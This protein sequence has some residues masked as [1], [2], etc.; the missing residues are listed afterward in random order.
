M[1]IPVLD[2]PHHDTHI[3]ISARIYYPGPSPAPAVLISPGFGQTKNSLDDQA[4]RFAKSGFVVLAYTPRGFGAS[5]G[6]IALN[7]PDYEVADA[8]GLLDWLARQP[9]VATDRPGDPRVGVTGGSYGGALA[10]LLAGTDPRVDAIAPVIT[11]NNLA[12][13]LIPNAATRKA[14]TVDTRTPAPAAFSPGGVF[15]K[16][17]A[18]NLYAAGFAGPA[19]H[20]GKPA[21]GNFLPAVCRAYTTLAV[22]GHAND[23]IQSLLARRSPASVTGHITAPTLLVQGERDTL[24]GLGQADENARQI[25]AAGATVK[26]VWYPGGH[27]GG[28]P[29]QRVRDE[30]TAWFA[31]Y[32]AGHGP[33]PPDTF[34]YGLAGTGNHASHTVVAPSYPGLGGPPVGRTKLGLHGRGQ[35]AVNPPGGAPAATSSL[36]GVSGALGRAAA[37]LARDVPGEYA[38][39]S[40]ARLESQARIAGA[41]T[42]R[43]RISAPAG[44]PPGGGVFFAKLYDVDQRGNRTLPGAGVAPFRIQHFPA[45]AGAVT[46]TVTLPGIVHAV[47][48]GHHLELV[49]ATTDRAY[50]GG[51]QPG[52]YRIGLARGSALAVPVVPGTTRRTGFPTGALIGI[53]VVLVLVAVTAGG[54]ALRRGRGSEVDPDRGRAPLKFLDVTKVYGR[55]RL[56]RRPGMRV[57]DEFTFEVESGQIVGLLGPNG[58][59]KTTALRIAMG[60]V[61]PTSGAVLVFGRRVRPGAP[62][63][64]RIGSF[65]EGAGFLPH[66]SGLANLRLYW[67]ATGRPDADAQFEHALEIAELGEAAHRKVGTYSQGMRQRLAIA[68]AMLGLPA[69]L[70]LDEPTNGLDPPQIREM[71]DVLRRYAAGGR[72]VVIS[73]HLLA[74]VEQTCTHIVVMHRGR[75]LASGAVD[76]VVAGGAISFSVDA[77]QEA[78]RSLRTLP[79]VSV[80]SLDSA[81]VHAELGDTATATA[82][83]TLVEAGIGVE[84]VGPRRRLEDA[85]LDLLGEENTPETGAE[86]ARP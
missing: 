20:G 33:K 4:R 8:R 25:S 69:L 30:I 1:T 15:K 66:E 35:L 5:G 2:G 75:R 7:D 61:R 68:Q 54:F 82:V 26:V 57:V 12:Q 38:R 19:G 70:V 55:N 18:A 28:P 24:F 17:W 11:Y 36:P 83:R 80:V 45:G 49:V 52:V 14:S 67:A 3:E 37:K 65:V 22:T 74:E 41:V 34:S 56:R 64:S 77:P 44:A 16:A 63:L 86:R 31:H 10:L 71:R 47:P 27:D 59:G 85:F 62:V 76:Q 48:A 53:G 72:T 40:S 79:G 43:L 78:A 32:L 73:S 58:A 21:C 50:A 39:F 84:R 23:R 13:A 60:L 81:A 9:Q 42:V 29:G 46:V 51:K 6:R